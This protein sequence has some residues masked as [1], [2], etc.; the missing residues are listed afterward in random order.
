MDSVQY[1]QRLL[2][3]LSEVDGMKFRKPMIMT[4]GER[5]RIVDAIPQMASA[6]MSFTFTIST[7]E[8][9]RAEAQ[10]RIDREGVDMLIVDYMQQMRTVEKFSS[11]HLRITHISRILKEMALEFHIP[12]IALSQIRRLEARRMPRLED[13]K[14]SGSIE[15]DADGVIIMHRPET[16]DDPSILPTDQALFMELV[17]GKKQLII[18]DVA[19]QRQGQI[20]KIRLIFEP[21]YMRFY[22]ID[23]ERRFE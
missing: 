1:G 16:T 3:W 13:L 22:C 12:V 9:L 5:E 18:I 4:D 15:Q 7:I 14:E 11:E 17:K 6:P 21:S 2:S 20:G 23:K 8:A 10:Y 19:K